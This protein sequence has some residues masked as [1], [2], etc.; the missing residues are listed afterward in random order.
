LL[1]ASSWP[2]GLS[3]ATRSR[4]VSSKRVSLIK[5]TPHGLSLWIK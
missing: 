4:K 1:I 2:D 5:G 3:M